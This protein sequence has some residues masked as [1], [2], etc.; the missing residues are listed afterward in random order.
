M[1]PSPLLEI[2]NVTF[3]GIRNTA[4]KVDQFRGIKFA[5]ITGRWKEP[6][7]LPISSYEV[8]QKSSSSNTRKSLLQER[9]STSSNHNGKLVYDATKF[10][11]ISP[12]P[13]EDVHGYY[14]VPP[15]VEI[16]IPSDC[17]YQDEFEMLNLTITRPAYDYQSSNVQ[18]Q[19]LPVAVFIHGGSNATGS[20]A[21]HLYNFS[22]L[23]SRSQDIGT[24]IITV[25]I[26]YR[27]GALGYLYIKDNHDNSTTT[28]SGKANWGLKDQLAGLKWIKQHITGFGGDPGN[29]SV[30]GL[31]AG[32][33]N[34]YFQALTDAMW[35][36]KLAET[37]KQ[38]L[39]NGADE[40][41]NEKLFERVG[42]M[43]G[44][45]NTMRPL[46]A[47]RQYKI[48]LQL[49]RE[50]VLG[51][52]SGADKELTIS[53]KEMYQELAKLPVEKLI[54]FGLDSY[55]LVKVWF[56][57]EDDDFIPSNLE[58]IPSSDSKPTGQHNLSE[59]FP[60]E[61]LLSDTKDEGLLMKEAFEA[62][63]REK[64]QAAL[65][66][67]KMPNDDHP[68]SDIGNHVSKAYKAH[69]NGVHTGLMNFYAD[70]VFHYPIHEFS[71]FLTQ[72]YNSGS[73]NRNLYRICF[74]TPNPYNQAFGAQHGVDILYLT[75]SYLDL[76]PTTHPRAAKTSEQIQD[77][78]INFFAKGRAWEDSTV[79]E[80]NK[81]S[82]AHFTED[83]GLEF[84]DEKVVEENNIRRIK[85]FDLHDRAGPRSMAYVLGNLLKL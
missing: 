21:N 50:Q 16:P 80:N 85:E 51:D 2:S 7:L 69:G 30:F 31:S 70:T 42:M 20:A 19:L 65:T 58:I 12:Q 74:D 29:I 24:P 72:N 67:I 55:G 5:D 41:N 53:N 27:L 71:R 61:I 83:F 28:Y 59:F 23:V 79:N 13:K 40:I 64:L 76:V 82:V 44:V 77:L 54:S 78:W 66:Q 26:Q 14:A 36:K 8:S 56:T 48:A 34:V 62:V 81:H 63:E 84:I 4:L 52:T 43:S 32:S 35:R 60:K 9:L 68:F 11:P 75:G 17:A 57:T 33:S 47:D 73:K 39:S 49:Y 15:N 1:S 10:G 18:N 3:R 6:V 37:Q 46:S 25:S 22:K 38:S 45:G